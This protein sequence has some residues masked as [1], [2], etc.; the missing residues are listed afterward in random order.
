MKKNKAFYGLFL[1]VFLAAL[2]FRLV[3]L[4]RRPMH[5]DEAN[6]AVKFGSLL[7]KGQYCY[8]K[9][10]HHGP[11]LYYL[12]LPFAWI[13]C[14]T[15]F[16][17]LNEV[18]LRLV[19]VFF[20]AGIILLLL[21]LKGGF[22]L[23]AIIFSGIFAAISPVMVFYSRFYIQETLL[24]F[25]LVG[26]I[27]A[28]WR[29]SQSRSL[30]WAAAAGFFSGMM[31]STK[32]TCLIAFGAILAGGI[33]TFLTLK[34]SGREEKI[35]RLPPASHL[36]VFLG[37]GVLVSL[38]LYSSF[39][40]NPKG[41]LDSVL[42]FRTYFERS[43]EAG[44]HS[45]PWYYY[46]KMLA[47][48]RY[49]AGPVW[50]EAL[51]LVLAAAGSIASFRTYGGKDSSP[52]LARFIFFY[53]LL[54]TVILSLISYKTP[55]NILPFY[56][57]FILLAGNGA[58]AVIR[59]S[60]KFIL[61]SLVI[62]ALGLGIFNLGLQSYRANFEYCADP[63]NPYVYAQTSTDFLNLIRRINEL[64][65]YHPDHDQML[66]KVIANPDETW[67]LPWYLRSFKQVGYWQEADAAGELDGPALIISS[68]DKTEEL[69]PRLHS[70]YQSEYYGLRP[71]V[72]LALYI[73]QDLWKSFLQ[74]RPKK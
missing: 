58:A 52:L 63:R 64:A 15:S 13:A 5:H 8:D 38:L 6:Q 53:T 25:F 22:S 74:K 29:Y 36:I 65:Q 61:K 67:P 46:L 21:L 35:I 31:Y 37:T 72:L 28:G 43:A 51:V 57:G 34:R 7:E 56:I 32:E 9:A 41:I 48:S 26:A 10:E 70:N 20:G 1:L 47:F 50:S 73:R 27:T 4:D 49:G 3:Q 60:K 19:P 39:L 42:A 55:W 23:E 40:Q 45:H 14:G 12:S 69:E 17:S 44:F 66:I 71:E 54:T 18:T 16:A 33:L 30:P 68:L 11:S 59:A 2:L 24:V 62:L